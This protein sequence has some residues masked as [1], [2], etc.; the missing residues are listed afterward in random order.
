MLMACGSSTSIVQSWRDP[1]THVEQGSAKMMLL[2][3][4][5]QDEATRRRTED[6]LGA[7]FLGRCGTF[8][9]YL[10]PLPEKIEKE[11]FVQRLR[12]WLRRRNGAALGGRDQGTDLRA[13]LLSELLPPSVWILR[14]RVPTY[15]DQGHVRADMSH[16]TETN[17]YSVLS[18][19]LMWTGITSSMDPVNF[20]T[21]LTEIVTAIRQK[22]ER[23]CFLTEPPVRSNLCVTH[24][25]C[26]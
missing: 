14:P 1:E 3:A 2:I 10:G 24:S 7:Q 16:R 22:M 21:M 18:G 17:F 26:R 5:V 9:R 25:C 12:R 6:E 20:S 19:K 15:A 11:A 8:Y 23:E 4:L 13:R